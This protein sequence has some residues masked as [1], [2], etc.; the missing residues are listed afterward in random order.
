MLPPKSIPVGAVVD[1]D[2]YGERVAGAGLPA[3]RPR[4]LSG[5]LAAHFT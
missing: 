5:R 2:Q 3:H 4:H 1:L